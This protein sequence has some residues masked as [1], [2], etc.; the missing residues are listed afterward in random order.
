VTEFDVILESVTK[1]FGKETAVDQL[2]LK[3]LKGEYLCILGP[4]GC[5]K[6]TTLRMIAGLLQPEDGDIYLEG[7]RVNDIPPY[8]RVTATVFQSFALFPHLTVTK[9]IEF[10]LKMRRIVL[11]ERKTKVSRMLNQMGLTQMATRMPEELSMGERQR[12]ALAKSLIIEPQVLLLDEPLSSIDVTMKNKILTDIREIHDRLGLTF[13]HVTHDPEEAMAN[14]DRI[15]LMNTGKVEQLGS[16]KEIFDKPRS[17]FVAEFFQNSNIID[18]EVEGYEAERVIVVN[19]SGRFR[20]PARGETPAV[21]NDVAVVI[22]YDKVGLGTG[23]ETENRVD[24]DVIGEEIVGAVITYSVRLNGDKVFKFQT[25]MSLEIPEFRHNANVSL[26][27]DP[28]DATIL[29]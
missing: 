2:C 22:R 19:D 27:W 11:S 16:P 20:V 17:R 4:S 12:V 10:G 1:R 14:A 8:H 26:V 24:G 15:M 5:G 9:N 29:I 18:G 23:M 28:D 3:V 21:G 6:T 7:Q 25:H 13:I